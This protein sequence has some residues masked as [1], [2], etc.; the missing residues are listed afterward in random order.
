MACAT[1]R[2]R[3]VSAPVLLAVLMWTILPL[4]GC[5]QQEISTA[6]GL[7][8]AGKLNF[9]FEREGETFSVSAELGAGED[10]A[11][12]VFC[13]RFLAPQT[14]SGLVICRKSEGGVVEMSMGG[15]AAEVA[16][17]STLLVPLRALCPGGAE[18]CD[19]TRTS[20]GVTLT[21]KR[22]DDESYTLVF[23]GGGERP[24]RIVYRYAGGSIELTVREANA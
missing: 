10:A 16:A 17:D 15:P 22:G 23:G 7:A 14:L 1:R 19:T 6:S 9:S 12:R 5:G 8:Q 24:T 11:T 3:Q 18:L 13:F 2:W 4:M 21:L 20:E